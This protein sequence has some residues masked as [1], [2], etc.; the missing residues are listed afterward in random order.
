M[1]R[2]AL[3]VLIVLAELAGTSMA[4]GSKI[5]LLLVDETESLQA[6]LMVQVYARA[7]QETGLFNLEAK[8]VRVRSSYD[9]PLGVNPTDKKYELIVIVPKGIEDG[10]VPQIWLITKPI[11][12]QT[13]PELLKALA[14]IR[15]QVDQGSGGLF[16]ALTV[17]DD[18]ILG[19]F[20]T[21]FERNGWLK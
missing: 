17:M 19:I 20:A 16:K 7:L 9:D 12:P 18:A 15:Q 14:L 1:K 8:I 3:L 4:Q 2:L 6:S 10:S 5:D 21:I 13:R 11:G